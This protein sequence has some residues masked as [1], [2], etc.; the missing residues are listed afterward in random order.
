MS[1]VASGATTSA[2]DGQVTGMRT[3]GGVTSL[4]RASSH[5]PCTKAGRRQTLPSASA[6]SANS[7]AAR[8]LLRPMF[9]KSSTASPPQRVPFLPL[10]R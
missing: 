1:S 2:A 7:T 3:S 5:N 4:R 8:A 6:T 10:P 9:S